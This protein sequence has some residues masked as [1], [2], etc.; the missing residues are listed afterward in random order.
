MRKP[1]AA[2]VATIA[3]GIDRQPI[4]E[5]LRQK[6]KRYPLRR[7]EP[8]KPPK[9]IDIAPRKPRTKAGRFY[10]KT[11]MA[12]ALLARVRR[13]TFRRYML[14]TILAH[15]DVREA[16]SAH[17]RSGQHAKETLNFKWAEANGYIRFI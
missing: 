12:D 5:A 8:P 4:V 2:R 9:T 6:T 11:P 17:I 1:L 13:G 15:T 7:T 14:E 16:T 10:E 3:K